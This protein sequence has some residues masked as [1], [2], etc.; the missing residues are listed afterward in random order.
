MTRT[1]I[2]IILTIFAAVL[3]IQAFHPHSATA[4]NQPTVDA[5]PV[6]ASLEA[7]LPS[8]QPPF[9]M[10]PITPVE[11]AGAPMY[12]PSLNDASLLH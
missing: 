2:T 4:A 5:A 10:T 11:S 7:T 8:V 9:D 12:E 6:S 3:L 1:L